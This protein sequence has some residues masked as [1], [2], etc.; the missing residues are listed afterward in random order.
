MGLPYLHHRAMNNQVKGDGNLVYGGNNIGRD[1]Y[2]YIGNQVHLHLCE[3]QAA[4]IFAIAIAFLIIVTKIPQTEPE[5]PEAG[6]QTQTER[7]QTPPDVRESPAPTSEPTS[8]L[9]GSGEY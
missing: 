7:P 1:S 4:L 8:S 6:D 9:E 5:A 3:I 2:Q